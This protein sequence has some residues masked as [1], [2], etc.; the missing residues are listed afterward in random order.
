M[1][2]INKISCDNAASAFNLHFSISDYSSASD[3]PGGGYLAENVQ[4]TQA[5]SPY[6]AYVEVIADFSA[7]GQLKPLSL[8]W[9]DGRKYDVDCI[10]RADRRANLKARGAGIRYV[11]RIQGQPV[12]LSYK[13]NRFWFV[14]RKTPRL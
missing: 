9:E 8:I 12:E 13:E 7:D 10:I 3:R 14:S 4:E 6:K 2:T 11:C 1:S 5:I